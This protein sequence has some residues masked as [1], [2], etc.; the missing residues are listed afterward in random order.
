MK[1]KNLLIFIIFLVAISCNKE[2]LNNSKITKSDLIGDFCVLINK[3]YYNSYTIEEIV[4]DTFLITTGYLNLKCYIESYS[5]VIPR[6]QVEIP[7]IWHSDGTV[8]SIMVYFYGTGKKNSE[9][10]L[11]TLS[12]TEEK[13][14]SNYTYDVELKSSEIDYTGTFISN[15]NDAIVELLMDSESDSLI[16]KVN[17]NYFNYQD[18][19]L[20][21]IKAFNN[22]CSYSIDY[23]ISDSTH[24]RGSISY[25][26]NNGNDIY[27]DFSECLICDKCDDCNGSEETIHYYVNCCDTFFHF[28]GYKSN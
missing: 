19:L 25:K 2:S 14:E 3:D 6:Q 10:G 22:R 7:D 17:M 5:L 8:D 18:S 28:E 15:D 23:E 26:G 11:I 1:T 4:P 12:I 27:I 24:I 20:I 21:E 13:D 16:L 9:T